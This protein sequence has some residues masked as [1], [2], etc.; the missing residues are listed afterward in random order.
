MN[1]KDKLSIYWYAFD[2]FLLITMTKEKDQ[3]EVDWA[4]GNVV[5]EKLRKSIKS[6]A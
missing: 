5:M 2:Q 3:T 1:V 4:K 6:G